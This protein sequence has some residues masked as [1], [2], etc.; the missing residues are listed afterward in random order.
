MILHLI[1]ENQYFVSAPKKYDQ[2]Q[3]YADVKN[4]FSLTQLRGYEA[5]F[6]DIKATSNTD[7]VN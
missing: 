1:N 6:K 3:L 7:P 4:S 2:K 5:H